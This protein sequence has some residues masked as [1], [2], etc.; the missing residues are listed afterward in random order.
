M[1]TSELAWVRINRFHHELCS[2]SFHMYDENEPVNNIVGIKKNWNFIEKQFFFLLCAN[3]IWHRLYSHIVW[4]SSFVFAVRSKI[5]AVP[6]QN[7]VWWINILDNALEWGF[8]NGWRNGNAMTTRIL[9]IC[10]AYRRPHVHFC[11]QRNKKEEIRKLQ[12]TE[13]K[14]SFFVPD[15]VSGQTHP[16]YANSA[17][18]AIYLWKIISFWD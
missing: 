16:S 14:S 9:P 6:T 3:A 1:F 15:F 18:H 12:Q 8:A 4:V 10:C 2:K 11:E 17:G 7:F 5:S 13:K